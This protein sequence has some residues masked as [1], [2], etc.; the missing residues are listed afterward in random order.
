VAIPWLNPEEMRA[1]RAFVQ[2]EAHLRTAL[3]ADLTPYGLTSGDYEVLVVL[4]EAENRQMR[5]CD[6]AAR[7][8][9]T[10]SGLTRRLDGLV[11]AG[12]VDRSPSVCDR[13]VMLA[14]VTE[15]G[16]QAMADASEAHV[17]SVRLHLI[18]RLSPEQIEQLGDIFIAVAQGLGRPL[19]VA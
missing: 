16:M 7:L 4:S 10:P 5:M 9:L 18:D 6:L 14:G 12:Q 1:W 15:S 3:E 11:R 13:R 8:G 2:T 19:T 17:R